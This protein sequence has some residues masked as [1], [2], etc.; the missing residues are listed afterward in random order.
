MT[1]WHLK[2]F[3]L[4]FYAAF[5]ECFAQTDRIKDIYSLLQGLS[6]FLSNHRKK[7]NL[8]SYESQETEINV[9]VAVNLGKNLCHMLILLPKC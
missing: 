6:G 5:I 3:C 7:S 9:T 8:L 4:I 2:D 1:I